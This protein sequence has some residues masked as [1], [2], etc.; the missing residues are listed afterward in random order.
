MLKINWV[1]PEGNESYLSCIDEFETGLVSK[2]EVEIVQSNPGY[3][4]LALFKILLRIGKRSLLKWTARREI[5]LSVTMGPTFDALLPQYLLTSANFIYMYDAWPRYHNFIAK[6]CYILNVKTIFF[7]SEKS[8]LLFN[9][10]K[11]KTKAVWLPEAITLD[12]YYYANYESKDIDVL[13]FGRKY[14]KYHNVIVNLLSSA[15]RLHLFEVKKGE[16]IFKRRKDFL[17]GLSRAKISICVPSNITHPERAENISS[18]TLRYLQCMAAKCLI[19]GVMP[20]EM[21]KLFTYS[22]IIEIDFERPGEQLIEL[23]DNY[24]LYHS[25]IERNYETVKENHTWDV[26]IGE[27]LEIIKHESVQ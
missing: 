4:K 3:F 6:A 1:R 11:F 25:L 8:A 21:K 22:P 13:E 12:N 20:E 18:M 15:K 5:S 17:Q 10:F 14:D 19:V 27:M 23:L 2:A 7:S 24:S 9:N 16:V 26:R